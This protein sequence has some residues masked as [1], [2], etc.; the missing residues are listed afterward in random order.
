[1][2]LTREQMIERAEQWK[3]EAMANHRGHY[4]P[5]WERAFIDD[6]DAEFAECKCVHQIESVT[7][8]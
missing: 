6:R 1:M 2:T 3:E 4:C 7:T 5:A 8:P